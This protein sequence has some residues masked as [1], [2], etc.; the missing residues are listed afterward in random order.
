[1]QANWKGQINEI[2]IE[3]QIPPLGNTLI[4]VN[5]SFGGERMAE[6]DFEWLHGQGILRNPKIL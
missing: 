1:M 2:S 3:I 5:G 6:C 4:Q